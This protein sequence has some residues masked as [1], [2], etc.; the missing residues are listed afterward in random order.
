MEIIELKPGDL[1]PYQ[2]NNKVHDITQ[3]DRIANSIKEF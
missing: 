1:I 3:V 2:F